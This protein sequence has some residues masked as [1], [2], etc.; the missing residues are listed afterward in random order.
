MPMHIGARRVHISSHLQQEHKGANLNKNTKLDEQ[1]P[2]TNKQ[3]SVFC[4]FLYV[5][6]GNS[7]QCHIMPVTCL[8]FVRDN[9][10]TKG[11]GKTKK[12]E[13]S[14]KQT[15]NKTARTWL[16]GNMCFGLSLLFVWFNC[17]SQ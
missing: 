12:S 8:V 13:T 7:N 14:T 5:S 17:P 2:Q 11:C 9:V 3:N 16:Q 6:E 10:K 4:W 1:H 15:Q